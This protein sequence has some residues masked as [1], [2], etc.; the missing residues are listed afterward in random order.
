MKNNSNHKKTILLFRWAGGKYYTLKKISQFWEKFEHGEYR[1][2][3]LGGGA[4]FWA[5]PKVKFNWLNDIDQGLIRTLKFIKSPTNRSKLLKL[6]ENE[7]EATKEKYL[8]VKNLEPKSELEFVYKYYYL[9]RTSF[10]GK[11]KNPSWGYR[12]KRS[13][14]PN[15]WKERIKPCGE[16]LLDTKLTSLDFTEVMMAKANGN[17]VL[18]FLDPPYFHAK[19]ESHYSFSFN[20]KDHE[21][22]A[23]VCK[24]TPHSFFLTYDDCQEIRKLYK[25]ANIFALQFYY[26]LDNSKDN[27]DRRKVG[28]ELVITNYKLDDIDKQILKHTFKIN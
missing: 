21:R 11:M 18:M 3:F 27:G 16:K 6:F 28:F 17:K 10:S 14:P 23:D 8:K 20:R 1:E 22:L 9:N 24:K 2:P 19:Q 25:W 4:I 7:E 12:P 15:R 13:L 26:R 5:K